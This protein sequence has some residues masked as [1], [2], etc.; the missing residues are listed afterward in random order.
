MGSANNQYIK[1]MN[2]KLPTVNEILDRTNWT[3]HSLAELVSFGRITPNEGAD[4]W[5]QAVQAEQIKAG[6]QV[7]LD[8][9][10]EYVKTWE[11]L[12]YDVL[13][14]LVEIQAQS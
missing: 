9:I 12:E 11:Q 1:I 14:R 8:A 6:Y 3:G 7:P 2:I 5:I 4:K 13:D 10:G